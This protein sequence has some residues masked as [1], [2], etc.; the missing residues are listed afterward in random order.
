[1]KTTTL[2]ITQTTEE[3]NQQDLEAAVKLAQGKATQLE[4]GKYASASLNLELGPTQIEIS[5]QDAP[6]PEG[7]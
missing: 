4:L 1:M 2:T 6:T 7:D 5:M 3:F